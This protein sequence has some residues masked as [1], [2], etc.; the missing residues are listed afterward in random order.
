MIRKG[1]GVRALSEE[2]LLRQLDGG[3]GVVGRCIAI[4]VAALA[5]LASTLGGLAFL[6]LG[7]G[8]GHFLLSGLTGGVR[9]KERR[10]RSGGR[11]FFFFFFFSQTSILSRLLRDSTARLHFTSTP[12]LLDSMDD[13]LD[14]LIQCS[15]YK[16][17]HGLWAIHWMI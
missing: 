5:L 7:G 10:K 16:E 3:R 1:I 2:L 8:S 12:S 17:M 4:L 13:G 14:R 15:G 11:K 6:A 9:K